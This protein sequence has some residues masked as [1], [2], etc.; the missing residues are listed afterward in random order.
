MSKKVKKLVAWVWCLGNIGVMFIAPI[1]LWLTT[2]YGQPIPDHNG[3]VIMILGSV[4]G[5]YVLFK[6]WG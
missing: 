1:W 2:S 6:K 3:F 5:S 4:L